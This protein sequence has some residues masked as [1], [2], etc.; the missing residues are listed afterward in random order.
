MMD[1][2]ATNTSN[3]M[4]ATVT[5]FGAALLLTDDIRAAII[6]A[7]NEFQFLVFPNQ[8]LTQA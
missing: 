1:I 4:G 7:L 2:L 8:T 3:S 6:R 5:N